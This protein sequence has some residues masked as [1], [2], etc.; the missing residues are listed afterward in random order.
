MGA[1]LAPNHPATSC[2][3]K[4]K[5]VEV[6]DESGWIIRRKLLEGTAGKCESECDIGSELQ[7]SLNSQTTGHKDD[8]E[9]TDWRCEN[10]NKMVPGILC[11]RSVC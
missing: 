11:S 9:L 6:A 4:V 3:S 2:V 7:K 10:K 8:Q 5:V 1:H